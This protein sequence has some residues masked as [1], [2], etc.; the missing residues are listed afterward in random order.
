MT[1]ENSQITKGFFF[2]MSIISYL[3]ATEIFYLLKEY[4]YKLFL[5]HVIT[6]WQILCR[7]DSSYITQRNLPVTYLMCWI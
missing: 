1:Q 5:A 3:N 2:H 4:I 7:V 6:L